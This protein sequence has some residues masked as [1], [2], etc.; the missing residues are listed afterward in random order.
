MSHVTI[1][2]DSVDDVNIYLEAK[3]RIEQEEKAKAKGDS[4]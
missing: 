1:N 4:R 2:D 3:D